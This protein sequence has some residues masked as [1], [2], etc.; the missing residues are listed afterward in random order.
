MTKRMLATKDRTTNKSDHWHGTWICAEHIHSDHDIDDLR[1]A[2]YWKMDMHGPRANSGT[3]LNHLI[4][5]SFHSPPKMLLS[6]WCTTGGV[7]RILIHNWEDKDKYTKSLVIQRC[8]QGCH[9]C[10]KIWK[11]QNFRH[12]ANHYMCWCLEACLCFHLD[13]VAQICHL[14]F[15]LQHVICGT[16]ILQR[17]EIPVNSFSYILVCTFATLRATSTMSSKHSS[18][19]YD[20]WKYEEKFE[21]LRV[22]QFGGCYTSNLL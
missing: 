13:G 20:R 1:I 12:Q 2:W 3:I 21:F 19:V 10:C 18:T 5:W 9:E 6:Q 14:H 22:S 11:K 4:P 16:P 17:L 7:L 8:F 15:W